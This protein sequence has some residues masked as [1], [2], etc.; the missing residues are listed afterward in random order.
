MTLWYICGLSGI[1][2]GFLCDSFGIF[3]VARWSLWDS[4]GVTVR[5]FRPLWVHFAFTLGIYKVAW[6]ITLGLLECR[7]WIFSV[8]LR[9]QRKKP[10]ESCG[11]TGLRFR[12]YV[13]NGLGRHVLAKLRAHVV[14]QCVGQTV[15]AILRAQVVPDR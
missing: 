2:L 3:K 10:T 4:F 14:P 8:T 13:N 12:T 11:D 1:A 6:G 9:G 15:L 5:S 7:F